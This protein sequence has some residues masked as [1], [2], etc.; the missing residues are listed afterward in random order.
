MNSIRL[1]DIDFFSPVHMIYK[2]STFE[3][4]RFD[5][6]KISLLSDTHKFGMILSNDKN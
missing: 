2:A 1:L 5:P 4:N 6:S 3:L